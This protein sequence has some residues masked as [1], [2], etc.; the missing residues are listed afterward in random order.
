MA[1]E[2]VRAWIEEEASYIFQVWRTSWR[3]QIFVNIGLV[4][5]QGEEAKHIWCWLLRGIEENKMMLKNMLMEIEGARF[6]EQ[7]TAVVGK[8]ILLLKNWGMQNFWLGLCWLN[9]V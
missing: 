8:K 6:V 5:S 4:H 2:K 3:D 9:F 1:K 7:K